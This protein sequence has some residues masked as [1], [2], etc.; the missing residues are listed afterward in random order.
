MASNEGNLFKQLGLSGG[1]KKAPADAE[2]EREDS[3]RN[4]ERSPAQSAESGSL[5]DLDDAAQIQL[6]RDLAAIFK[7]KRIHPVFIFGSKGSGKTTFLAS[8]FR[9]I[10]LSVESGASISLQDDIFPADDERWRKH[11]T[12][13]RDVFYKKVDGVIES[14]APG[15]TLE[16]SPFF[17]PIK[18]TRTTGEE[19]CFAF[20]EGKGEWYMPDETSEVPYK[21][22]KGLLQGLLQQFSD[23]ATVIY[24]APFT[25]GSYQRGEAME[26]SRSVDL[27]K[28]DKGL[29]GALNEYIALRRA[30]FHQDNHLFL[31]TKWDIFCGGVSSDSF[32]SPDAEELQQAF[33]ERF[34]LAWTRFQNM[35]A[36]GLADNKI[37]SAYC[38]GI[39]DEQTVQRP[40]V[41]DAAIIDRYPRKI[42]D[43]LH[44]GHVGTP[45]YAD[46]QPKRPNLIDRFIQALRG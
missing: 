6:G 11:A 39:I 30:H 32:Y 16:P 7:D 34:E 35:E 8:L 42:W 33:S 38:A 18:L 44:K 46:M 5:A 28:S 23:K 1:A 10:H 40:A 36:T 31:M 4:E 2:S 41:D 12:W 45:L 25:T 43:W 29:V 15:A 22:F 9:Y 21:P 19:V 24:I 3:S 27:R 20:L 37:F 14:V 13:A 26:S 17:V